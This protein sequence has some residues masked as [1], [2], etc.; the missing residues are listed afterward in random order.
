M[1][2]G[3]EE[4]LLSLVY[5]KSLIVFVIRFNFIVKGLSDRLFDNRMGKSMILLDLTCFYL[6]VLVHRPTRKI[7]SD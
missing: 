4:D 5:G 7:K 6:F 2:L 3:R 1:M